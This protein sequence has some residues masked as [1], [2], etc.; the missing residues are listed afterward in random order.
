MGLEPQDVTIEGDSG[1]EVGHGD[2]HM[3]DAGAIRHAIPPSNF[4]I[5]SESTTG[6]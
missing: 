4:L 2:A 5:E 6:E 3:R 1:V